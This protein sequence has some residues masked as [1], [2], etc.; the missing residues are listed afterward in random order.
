MRTKKELLELLLAEWEKSRE[1]NSEVLN[2][3]NKYSGLCPVVDF[4]PDL[5]EEEREFLKNIIR[6]ELRK[7]DKIAYLFLSYQHQLRVE[8]LKQQIELCEE[9]SKTA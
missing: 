7:T 4:I 1:W 8:W 3:E 5:N 6:S 9:E 2:G